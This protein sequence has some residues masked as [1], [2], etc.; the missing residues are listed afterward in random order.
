M[1]FIA[2]VPNNSQAVRN[3]VCGANPVEFSWRLI[4]PGPGANI[5]AV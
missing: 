3:E 4:P 5:Q 2:Q 1:R